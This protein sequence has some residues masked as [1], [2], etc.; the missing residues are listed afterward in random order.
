[1]P[2]VE[3]KASAQIAAGGRVTHCELERDCGHRQEALEEQ[4]Q[5]AEDYRGREQ[6]KRETRKPELRPCNSP[7]WRGEGFPH[8]IA[9]APKKTAQSEFP[10]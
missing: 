4:D 7:T 8:L 2:G 1:M 6:T 5:N 3:V 10:H 9:E